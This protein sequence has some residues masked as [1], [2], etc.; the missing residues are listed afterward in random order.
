MKR[1]HWVRPRFSQKED[2]EAPSVA[3]GLLLGTFAP[4]T[5]VFQTLPGVC[6]G[7][8]ARAVCL[9]RCR[10]TQPSFCTWEGHGAGRRAG[11]QALLSVLSEQMSA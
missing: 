11:E 2:S 9:V 1:L 3:E 7:G 4:F 8:S 10:A 6:A 5:P